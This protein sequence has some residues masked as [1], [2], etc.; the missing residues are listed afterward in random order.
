MRENTTAWNFVCEVNFVEIRGSGKGRERGEERD[1]E[2][3]RDREREE[4]R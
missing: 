2:I 1:G 4:R 3:E